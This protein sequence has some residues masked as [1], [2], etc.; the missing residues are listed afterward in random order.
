MLFGLGLGL[1][2]AVLVYLD[3]QQAAAPPVAVT[4]TA[5]PA[6]DPSVPAAATAETGEGEGMQFEFYDL[7]PRFEVV[8]PETELEA[9]PD[10]PDTT[11]P[12]LEAPGRYVL[13]AGSFRAEADAEGRR[14]SLALLGIESSIQRVTIDT[15]EYHR[16]R[17]GPTSDLDSL[18]GIRTRLWDAEIEVLLIKLPD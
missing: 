16:V 3:G 14:A 2:V 9:R 18:N 12:V 13:Q 10:T 1:T 7:L 8:L 17:I 11:E 4:V 15:D 6:A 5:P